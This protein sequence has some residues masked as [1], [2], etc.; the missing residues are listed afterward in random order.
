MIVNSEY[1]KN[2]KSVIEN[3]LSAHKE[4]N[5]FILK[6]PNKAID[7]ITKSITQ[8]AKKEISIDIIEK[9]FNIKIP[10]LPKN[11]LLM[12]GILSFFMMIDIIIYGLGS[13]VS[14]LCY[15]F[16]KYKLN[17]YTK[18]FNKEYSH[19]KIEYL[20]DNLSCA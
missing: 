10:E 16:V 5:K 1:A 3:F 11:L 14:I 12:L 2:N 9:S 13:L 7:S 18:R 19:L 6:N 4:A 15:P 20:L 17:N 8:I